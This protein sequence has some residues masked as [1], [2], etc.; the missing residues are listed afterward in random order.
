MNHR[1]SPAREIKGLGR[2]K[3]LAGPSGFKEGDS[4]E[5][6]NSFWVRVYARDEATCVTPIKLGPPAKIGG[7]PRL[8]RKTEGR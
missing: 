5:S 1:M 8:E 3:S 4:C 7:T 2:K 6:K